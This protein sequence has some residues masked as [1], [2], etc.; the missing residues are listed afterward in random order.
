MIK[1]DEIALIVN[2]TEGRQAITDSASIRR[3]ALQR[4]VTYTT[5]LAGAEA[6]CTALMQGAISEVYRVQDLHKELAG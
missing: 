5:T 1:N 6:L 2:T 4:R 3:S